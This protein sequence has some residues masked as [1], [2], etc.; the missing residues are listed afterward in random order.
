[1][2][3]AVG[4]L[5]PQ[6][7]PGAQEVMT[8]QRMARVSVDLQRALEHRG[9]AEDVM[10]RDGDR[11]RIARRTDTVTVLGAVLHPHVVP[12]QADRSVEYYVE[13]SGG[14]TLDASAA[15]VV[16]VR[17]NGDATPKRSLG[18]IL[19][20]DM[21]VVPNTALITSF[22]EKWEKYGDVGTALSGVLSTLVV[23]ASLFK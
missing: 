14:Y 10:L 18:R 11:L 13:R 15:H 7:L 6:E 17:Q 5:L 8:A 23:A 21:I 9:S 2:G 22:R 12:Y 4:E 3:P 20:G 19:P 16:V 1:M